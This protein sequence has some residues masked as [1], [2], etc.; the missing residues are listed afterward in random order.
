MHLAKA[1]D[2]ELDALVKKLLDLDKRRTVNPL[3]GRWADE[4]MM[5]LCQ[6][7]KDHRKHLG[8]A[9]VQKTLK[10]LKGLKLRPYWNY[11]REHMLDIGLEF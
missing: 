8:E 9:E 1:S 5:K 4:H 3:D 2:N 7:V 10:T 11:C 6:Y